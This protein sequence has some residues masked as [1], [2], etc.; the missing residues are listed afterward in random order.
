MTFFSASDDF[1]DEPSSFLSP[2][3]PPLSSPAD[4]TTLHFTHLH[5]DEELEHLDFKRED[6]LATFCRERLNHVTA[7]TLT[8]LLM[9]MRRIDTERDRILLP[10]TINNP[11]GGI[12]N[13]SG[14]FF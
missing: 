9:E 14:S 6:K 4:D 11:D 12:P 7:R 2:D 3:L 1:I 8:V 13:S 5:D 10:K